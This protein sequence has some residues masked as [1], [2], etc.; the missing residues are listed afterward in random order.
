MTVAPWAFYSLVWLLAIS[1]A[2]NIGLGWLLM[3]IQ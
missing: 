1:A 3:K 2:I